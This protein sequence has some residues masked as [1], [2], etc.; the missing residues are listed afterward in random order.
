MS[1]HGVKV[2]N[3]FGEIKWSDDWEKA[4]LMMVE[5]AGILQM[6]VSEFVDC[7]LDSDR[8]CPYC[9]TAGPETEH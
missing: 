1:G 3:D 2:S 4:L 5:G 9:Q 6:T 8:E 7:M